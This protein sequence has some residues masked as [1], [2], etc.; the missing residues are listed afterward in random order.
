MPGE[1]LY[2]TRSC[3]LYLLWRRRRG[4]NGRRATA[5]EL[6]LQLMAGEAGE[7]FHENLNIVSVKK[8]LAT[9]EKAGLIESGEVPRIGSKP[10]PA[11][12]GYRFPDDGPML[13]WSSTARIILDLYHHPIRPVEETS[14]IE[15]LLE[16]GLLQDD[17]GQPSTREHI[18]RQLAYC[19]KND[20]IK[21]TSDSP[22]YL[23]ST[24][25]VDLELMFL[26][27]IAEPKRPPIASVTNSSGNRAPGA[28]AGGSLWSVFLRA[29]KSS[30]RPACRQ[31]FARCRSPSHRPQ[32]GICRRLPPC[33]RLTLYQSQMPHP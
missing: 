26:E 6:R 15:L 21:L 22:R 24:N 17:T 4:G 16:I 8:A 12:K 3:V 27:K 9:L 29:S 7:Q 14:F 25:R 19:Q 30:P 5:E 28:A 10:G 11:P 1:G 20:Y 2:T 13:T 23:S 32:R 18:V 31:K 33:A